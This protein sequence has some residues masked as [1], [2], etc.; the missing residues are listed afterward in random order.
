MTAKAS[1]R[2]M[3]SPVSVRLI[4]HNVKTQVKL[5]VYLRQPF[6]PRGRH[7]TSCFPKL[8]KAVFFS[9]C[10]KWSEPNGTHSWDL[11]S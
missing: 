6:V 2:N 7:V 1:P 11:P 10:K 8:T 3:T 9:V 4:P 5:S